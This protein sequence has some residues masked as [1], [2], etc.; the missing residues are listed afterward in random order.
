MAIAY[1]SIDEF[2]PTLINIE[3]KYKKLEQY[4]RKKGSY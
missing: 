4:T 2:I 1:T 3:K